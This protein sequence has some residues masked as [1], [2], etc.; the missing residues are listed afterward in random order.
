MRNSTFKILFLACLVF[1]AGFANG[2][3]KPEDYPTIGQSFVKDAE[4]QSAVFKIDFNTNQPTSTWTQVN[5]TTVE[6]SWGKAR[7]GKGFAVNVYPADTANAPTLNP[8]DDFKV[9]S[10]RWRSNENPN[11]VASVDSLQALLAK[12]EEVYAGTADSAKNTLD[13]YSACVFD[14]D[15]DPAN[16]AY[17]IHPG[18]YKKLEHEFVFRFAGYVLLSDFQFTIDTYDLGNTDSTATYSLRVKFGSVDTTVQNFYVTGSG[19]MEVKLAEATG[20]EVSDFDNQSEVHI[21]LA[22][23][24]TNT[25]IAEGVYD[26]VVVVDNFMVTFAL[27]AWIE[28]D[29]GIEGGTYSNADDPFMGV[30]GEETMIAMPLKTKNRIAALKII[31][32]LYKNGS[33]DKFNKMFTFLDTM[34]VMANDGSGNYTVEVPYTLTPAT[35]DM[36]T[37]EWSNQSIEIAAPDMLTDDDLMFYFK[38][39]PEAQTYFANLEIDAGVRFFYQVNVQGT[40]STTIDLTDVEDE[41][42]LVD[43]LGMIPDSSTVLLGPGKTYTIG[44]HSLD[45]SVVFTSSDPM[46]SEMPHLICDSNFDMVDG[47]SVGFVVFRNIKL[48][49][50]FDSDYIFNISETSTLDEFVLESCMVKSLR[51]ILRIKDNPSVVNNFSVI[52]C[53]MDSVKNYGLFTMDKDGGAVNDVLLKNS[54]FSRF[55][56]FI[57]SKENTQSI[58]MESCTFFQVPDVGR[59]FMRYDQGSGRDLIVNGVTIK[60]C[61]FGHGW[62]MD[63]EDKYSVRGFD[64]SESTQF[65]VSETI[66]TNDFSFSSDTIQELAD[67]DVYPGSSYEIWVDPM[68]GNFN[69]INETWAGFGLGDPRW[70]YEDTTVY[71]LYAGAGTPEEME[72]SDSLAVDYL[73]SAGYNVMYVDDNDIGV[74]GYDYSPYEALVVGESTSSSRIVPFGSDDG[75]P[76][77]LVSMEGFGVKNDKWGWMSTNDYF[78]ESRDVVQNMDMKILDNAHYITEELAVDQVVSL[79][80]AE[81]SGD[82][83]A[84]GLGLSYD[85]LGAVALGQN[86]NPAITEPMLWAI[87]KGTLLGATGEYNANR[88]VI[89]AANAKGL[90]MPTDDFFM[91]LD[92]SIQWVLGAGT[93][94]GIKPEIQFDN[95]VVF[96]PNPARE[97]AKLRF[98]VERMEE[99]SLSVYNLVGQKLN[100]HTP[101]VFTEGQ[102]EIDIRTNEMDNGMY[103]YL[104]QIGDQVHKGKFNVVR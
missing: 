35:F 99:V 103:I 22:T 68:N 66:T 62:D 8:N 81:A 5:D 15:G 47:A 7:T 12:W 52:N 60:K 1:M 95:D 41:Y 45:K 42:S 101:E 54:T 4:T 25:E 65:S 50:D 88:M 67:A 26:P 83:Y 70:V 10:G 80:T 90:D 32:N 27:P 55:Q 64:G 92:R 84:W 44:G 2:Q 37:Q 40:G 43:T 31:D 100:V 77:P 16:Q 104:L 14:V 24:G 28:P 23:D 78:Q 76:I 46:D 98:T 94:V 82:I 72:M 97:Y 93:T 18:I 69:W 11:H 59:Q 71:L 36:G 51:G 30:V 53:V 34:A 20:L 57:R 58:T 3:A 63:N 9:R 79:S 17:G 49:G 19:P 85:V 48:S 6:F 56:Y 21:F 13:N 89:F 96:Y 86:T 73:M 87:P 39:L 38:V 29:L 74:A 91:L 75:Y 33:G 61:V 102:H